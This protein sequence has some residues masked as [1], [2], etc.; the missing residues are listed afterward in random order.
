MKSASV[1]LTLTLVLITLL[2]G[3]LYAQQGDSLVIRGPAGS[4]QTDV[5]RGEEHYGPVTR[6]DTLWNIANRVRPHSSVSV[7]QVMSAIMQA[8]PH[9]FLD[10]NP[11][12]LE[13]GFLLRIPSLQE[14]Q[15][16]NPEAAR[17]HIELG[18]QLGQS[19][20]QLQANRQET[21]RTAAEREALLTQTRTDAVQALDGVRAE[22]AGEFAELREQLAQSIETTES[23]HRANDELR[24]RLDEIALAL[25]DIRQSM[26]SES[27]FQAQ[28]RELTEEQH[29]LRLSQ[30]SAEQ[31][32]AE[33]GLANRIMSSPIALILLAFVPALLMI[34]I[35]SMW[36]RRKDT[37]SSASESEKISAHAG[38]NEAAL[39]DEPIAPEDDFE[40]DEALA[41]FDD[42]D[43]DDGDDLSALEDEMLVPEES[44]D[45]SIRLD[46][47]DDDFELDDFDSADDEFTV[48]KDPVEKDSAE[49]DKELSQDE[50]D[51]LF[52]VGAD[53]ESATENEEPS[54]AELF[55]TD[56]DSDEESDEPTELRMATT[57][58]D[59]DFDF[60]QMMA[61]FD[62]EDTLDDELAA[63][64]IESLLSRSDQ[65][66]NE[67]DVTARATD[68]AGEEFVDIDTLIEDSGDDSDDMEDEESEQTTSQGDEDDN[69]AAQLDLARAYLEM[70]EIDEARETVKSVIDVAQGDI[71]EE[72]NELLNRID[73]S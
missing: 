53:D 34:I 37:S 12:A 11:N 36:L 6:T 19:Q 45:D 21:V 33:R 63:D 47:F 28:I 22:Y 24:A 55:A 26:V 41:D 44:S 32:A 59:D 64:D 5:R 20:Q 1:L 3:S 25:D 72:A 58:D 31:L 48:E 68:S 29:E 69:L 49:A 65:V 62:D 8:N 16:I 57:D 23:V 4:E 56:E 9:A 2:S 60:E 46:E 13:S 7:H 42:L 18:E 27:E 70:D 10:D 38:A 15:M 54:P 43:D 71:L 40:L 17:R 61:E 14:M 30:Q 66:L 73:N 39:I 52:A 35:A 67:S 51:Q 50:L